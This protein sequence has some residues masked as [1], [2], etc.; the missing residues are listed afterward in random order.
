VFSFFM[1]GPDMVRWELLAVESQSAYKL[2]VHHAHGVIVE[3]FKTSAAALTR[4]HE[5]EDLLTAARG[6]VAIR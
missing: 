4:Q 6:G 1:A 2:T 5:L 3:Y